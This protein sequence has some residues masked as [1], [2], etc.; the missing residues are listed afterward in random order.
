[1]W[2]EWLNFPV[3][4]ESTTNSARCSN[5]AIARRRI[6]PIP[7]IASHAEAINSFRRGRELGDQLGPLARDLAPQFICQC[8]CWGAE[9]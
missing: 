3:A 4:D 2:P 7:A 6:D 1:M 9:P 8:A 5:A